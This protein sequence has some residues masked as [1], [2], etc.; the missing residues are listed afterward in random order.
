MSQQP[1]A[2]HKR[3]QHVG[4]MGNCNEQYRMP[5]W[6][7]QKCVLRTTPALNRNKNVV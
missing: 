4:G 3:D 2:S 1:T 7:S 6:I 5:N